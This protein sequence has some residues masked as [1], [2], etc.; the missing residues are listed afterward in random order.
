MRRPE[1]LRIG[2]AA[3]YSTEVYKAPDR[4]RTIGRLIFDDRWPR[5]FTK[6]HVQPLGGTVDIRAGRLPQDPLIEVESSLSA[7]T[8]HWVELSTPG[9]AWH[10][11][12]VDAGTTLDLAARVCP[13]RLM[14]S[15]RLDKLKNPASDVARWVTLAHELVSAVGARNGTITVAASGDVIPDIARP[16]RPDPNDHLRIIGGGGVE[17]ES[18]E[19]LGGKYARYPRW[20]TYLHPEHVAAIGGR[21]QIARVVEPALFEE[22]GDLL[23]VQLTARI[24]DAWTPMM[25]EKR[26]RFRQL[27]QPILVR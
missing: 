27:M 8:T 24:E 5:P 1:P 9:D 14:A 13:F 7:S 23:Y 20:G 11:V 2:L 19:N 12:S 26:L 17:G 22:V 4:V 10:D 21:D 16:H 18:R 25:W 6:W 3:V 15:L